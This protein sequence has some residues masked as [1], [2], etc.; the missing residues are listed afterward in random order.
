MEC[1]IDGLSGF[2]PKIDPSF[3]FRCMYP[4]TDTWDPPFNVSLFA[5]LGVVLNMQ[6]YLLNLETPKPDW[7]PTTIV[8]QLLGKYSFPSS[9][10]CE[11][12]VHDSQSQITYHTN[13]QIM[14]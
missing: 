4:L 9:G 5:I 13:S 10:F 3:D 12:R 7:C 11:P 2:S 8:L 6:L 14:K 1:E